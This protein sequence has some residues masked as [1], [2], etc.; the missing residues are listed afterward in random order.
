MFARTVSPTTAGPDRLNDALR[1]LTSRPVY[2]CQPA[3]R[4]PAWRL[5][6]ASSRQSKPQ[7]PA[8]TEMPICLC[9][10]P[11][12]SPQE[13][14]QFAGRAP[15]ITAPDYDRTEARCLGALAAMAHTRQTLAANRAVGE[16]T[17]VCLRPA[18]ELHKPMLQFPS[19]QQD[20][21]F[22]FSLATVF[23]KD[24]STNTSDHRL[25]IR[26][27]F[28]PRHPSKSDSHEPLHQPQQANS[29]IA[30]SSATTALSNLQ[31]TR[32]DIA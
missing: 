13:K 1:G 17:L 7:L 21:L 8:P 27:Q 19:L 20:S 26:Q 23:R 15:I 4:V 30:C 29:S 6:L 32:E 3:I 11:T 2:L 25:P 10:A 9:P 5:P 28:P 16:G 18:S 12:P 24:H 22:Q 14:P 31:H